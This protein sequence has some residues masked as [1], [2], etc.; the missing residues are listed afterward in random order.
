MGVGPIAVGGDTL[1]IKVG[2]EIY[3]LQPDNTFVPL[4][5]GLYPW[6]S[7]TTGP[8][9]EAV[10]GSILIDTIPVPGVFPFDWP[11]YYFAL[12]VTPTGSL[13]HYYIWTT[14]IE[15]PPDFAASDLNRDGD[16]DG[17]D[18]ALLIGDPEMMLLADFALDFGKTAGL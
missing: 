9:S 17:S 13:S 8:V 2:G 16:V 18:L 12:L 1:E 10:L 15:M 11:R 6:K 14:G 7:N 3:L 5:Q 4:S